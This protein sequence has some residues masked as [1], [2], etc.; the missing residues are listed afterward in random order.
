MTSTK[1][2]HPARP[3]ESALF[4]LLCADCGEP[5][6]AHPSAL[7]LRTRAF[8]TRHHDTISRTLWGVGLLVGLWL[9]V[10][11]VAA[12]LMLAPKTAGVALLVVALIVS[13]LAAG[14]HIGDDVRTM[15]A[16]ARDRMS[17]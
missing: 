5:T 9:V 13:V 17:K 16:S 12:A 14:W 15:V 1:P 8:R 11:G 7:E 10:F 4:G 6:Y 2:T 3:V